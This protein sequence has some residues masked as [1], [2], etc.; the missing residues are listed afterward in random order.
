MALN[1][2]QRKSRTSFLMGMVITLVITGIVIILLFVQLKKKDDALKAEIGAKKSVYVLNSDVKSGQI[3][4]QDMFT[5]KKINVDEIPSN[6]TSIQEVIDSWYLQTKDGKA[7]YRDAKGLYIAEADSIIELYY[8][9]GQYYK[10]SDDTTVSIRNDPYIDQLEN[11]TRYF[12]VD[13]NSVDVDTRVYEDLNT[14]NCYI[15]KIENSTLTKQYLEF[16]SV[17]LL[18]KINMKKNTVITSELVVQSDAVVTDD[19]RKVEYNMV[20][21][22]TDLLTDDYID[23]RLMLPSGQNFIVI[24]KTQVEVP[25]N[26]DGTY[27]TDTISLNLREDEILTMSSAIVET[28]GINGA[29]LY[30]TKYTEPG[31]QDSALPTY[32]PNSAVTAEI[33]ENPNIVEQASKELAA[34]Y[35]QH[36]KDIRNQYLQDLINTQEGYRENITSNTEEEITNSMDARRRYLESLN[37]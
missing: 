22:P 2:M 29:K 5:Q 13:N 34:R 4:T 37:Y 19:I 11:E 3:L 9:N 6:A 15:Y 7:L 23:I 10:Q 8:E 18:A 35:S 28:Y 20:I 14:G 17:P 31:M 36:S 26:E 1:P 33:N 21:L 32:T 12:V 30:A 24:A 25:M 27:I 16:N